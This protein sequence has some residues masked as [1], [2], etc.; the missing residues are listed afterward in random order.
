MVCSG[1]GR[2]IKGEGKGEGRISLWPFIL[3]HMGRHRG[4]K[5]K[6]KRTASC[7]NP[8]TTNRDGDRCG[9]DH[10]PALRR[11]LYRFDDMMAFGQHCNPRSTRRS[12]S[13]LK[14]RRHGIVTHSS[15]VFDKSS[16]PSWSVRFALSTRRRRVEQS[17]ALRWSCGNEWWMPLRTVGWEPCLKASWRE[18][19]KRT[20]TIPCQH[21][22]GW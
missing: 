12:G 19:W 15:S 6:G 4:M 16:I 7:P 22:R 17:I 18:D 5:S 13:K 10:L 20:A 21:E 8:Y 11:I 9:I 3:A 2:W 1:R 14:D